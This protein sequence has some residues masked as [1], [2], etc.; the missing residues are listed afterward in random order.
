MAFPTIGIK[1]FLAPRYA[2]K[3]E[4]RIK[5]QLRTKEYDLK[6]WPAASIMNGR[7][8]IMFPETRPTSPGRQGTYAFDMRLT[9]RNKQQILRHRAY[10]AKHTGKVKAK[11]KAT[12]A[13]ADRSMLGFIQ[14]M[15]SAR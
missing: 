15:T 6:Q 7:Y 1:D 10:E 5:T 3:Q 12:A 9:S 2:E 4:L 13:H 14:E 11:A 8:P